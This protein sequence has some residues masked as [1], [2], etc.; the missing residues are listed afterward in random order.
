ML[1]EFN[2]APYGLIK[3]QQ[4]LKLNRSLSAFPER[5]IIIIIII[6]IIFIIIIIII[7]I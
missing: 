4:C 7:I 2:F 1:N 5:V 6:I 3:S